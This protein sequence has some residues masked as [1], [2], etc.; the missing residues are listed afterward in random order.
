MNKLFLA[1]AIVF[2]FAAGS[3]AQTNKAKETVE[4]NTSDIS[5]TGSVTAKE[6]KFETVPNPKVEFPGT[7]KR[8]TEWSSER[9]NLP[10]EVQPN[11]IYRDI[12]IKLKIVSVFA[13]IEKIVDEALGKV[14]KKTEDQTA[15]P[16][17]KPDE[18]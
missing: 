3:F 9:K 16:K 18:N 6:L 12:G 5:I 14:P 1:F 17:D 10:D 8:K 2:V 4:E 15:L 13:D 7:P 11:V